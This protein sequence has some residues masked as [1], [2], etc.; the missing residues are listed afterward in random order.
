MS[1]FNN[2]AKHAFTNQ[3]SGAEMAGLFLYSLY[4]LESNT[5]MSVLLWINPAEI[6]K[7]SLDVQGDQLHAN[8]VTNIQV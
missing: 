1:G 8:A 2:L 5:I 4:R 6:D 7:A 3:E